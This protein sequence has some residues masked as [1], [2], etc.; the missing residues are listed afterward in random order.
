MLPDRGRFFLLAAAFLSGGAG[1]EVTVEVGEQ[2]GLKTWEWRHDGISLR[3][4]QRLPD[5]TRAYLLARGFTPR[6]AD[7]VARGCLF[8]SMFRNDGGEPLD[9]DLDDWRVLHD[10]RESP[11]ITRQRWEERLAEAQVSKAG[12]IA[13]NWSLMPTRQHFEPG[14]YNWGMTS[15]GLPPGSRF[16]LRLRITVGGKPLEAL[17]EGLECAPEKLPEP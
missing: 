9:F 5:Q 15:Y 12:R 14:D 11:M 3:L 6:A 13:F 8:G 1:A 7:Q 16:G 4:V 10:G 2:T 17:V